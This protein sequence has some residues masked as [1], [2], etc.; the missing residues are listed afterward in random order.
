M[1]D[2]TLSTKFTESTNSVHPQETVIFY[3]GYGHY[4]PIGKCWHLEIQG[5]IFAPTKKHFRKQV[6]L[7]LLKRV[8][9]PER[10]TEVRQ[11]FLDRAHLFLNESRKGKSVPIA[12][13]QQSFSLPD[14]TRNGHFQTT[15]TLPESELEGAV[16]TDVYG[17]RFVLFCTH[18]S[19]EDARLFPG[20]VELISPDGISIVSDVDDTIKISDV[21][22][23]KE[24]L[25]NT[26]TREF[27]S[28]TGMKELYQ[29]WADAGCSFHYVSA[30]PWPL[31]RPIVDWLTE[32]QFPVGSVHLRYVG[33]QELRK[34]KKREKSFRTKRSIIETLMRT[35][36][37]RRFVLSGDSGERDAELYTE[38]ALSFGPQVERILIRR[39]PNGKHEFD[40]AKDI[41]SKLPQAQWTIFDEPEELSDFSEEIST[42][43]K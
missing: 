2:S 26:F 30:S 43:T 9:K 15:I 21:G 5:R 42:A 16:Q 3:R 22:N 14:S 36:P 34:D 33:L 11:R 12:I 37:N 1:D 7:H 13:A 29:H 31:Y 25:A 27:R 19:A 6:L 20:E 41:L 24:L 35:F 8:V 28:V 17:R 39:T 4:S 40:Q 32:D 10:S 23:K 38:I 18:L